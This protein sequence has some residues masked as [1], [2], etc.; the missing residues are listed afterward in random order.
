VAEEFQEG[1]LVIDGCVLG[2][3]ELV[4]LRVRVWEGVM[5]GLAVGVRLAV[6]LTEGLAEEVGVAVGESDIDAEKDFDW[7]GLVLIVREL[8]R[9]AVSEVVGDRVGLIEG[10][11]LRVG[12]PL[13]VMEGIIHV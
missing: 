11:P 7:E 2:L 9:V 13:G 1:E 5:D 10:V 12:V 4:G 6:W 3:T 8:V